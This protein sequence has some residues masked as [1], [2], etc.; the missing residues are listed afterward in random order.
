MIISF[1]IDNTLIPYSSEFEVYP[2]SFLQKILG[3]E[4]L[5]VRTKELIDKLKS[6][7]HE[8]W[9]YTTS[10][11]SVAKLKRI[12]LL[13]GIKIQRVINQTENQKVLLKNHP[14]S[15]GYRCR[16]WQFQYVLFGAEY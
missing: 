14:F 13:Q 12:F 1:D 8:I 7:G 3:T 11:R 10:F 5:R 2:K 9:V 16:L 6:D 15:P 4:M